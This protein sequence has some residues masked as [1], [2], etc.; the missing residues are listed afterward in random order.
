[1]VARILNPGLFTFKG[2]GRMARQ[3]PLKDEVEQPPAGTHPCWCIGFAY[4][5][6]QKG[7]EGKIEEKIAVMFELP[8]I[9]DSKGEPFVKARWYTLS[10]GAKSNLCKDLESWFSFQMSDAQRELAAQDASKLFKP[11]LGKLG[12]AVL[13]AGKKDADK[14][15]IT[16]IVA[17]PKGV[18]QPSGPVNNKFFYS[19]PD[20][21]QNSFG[22]AP[23]WVR[24]M[25]QKA[26]KPDGTPSQASQDATS[27][28]FGANVPTPS[29]EI[30]QPGTNFPIPD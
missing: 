6:W 13:E 24:E 1:M 10:L 3:I 4:L 9:K 20:D 8:T 16:K 7:F 22:K 14:V 12:M 27:F 2:T 17:W 25:Q 15:N 21:P 11:L 26:Q 28:N 30:P 19:D 23:D 29:E 5:G 18:P